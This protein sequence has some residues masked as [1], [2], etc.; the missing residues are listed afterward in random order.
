[1]IV[2]RRFSK[3]LSQAKIS[4][5]AALATVVTLGLILRLVVTLEFPNINH[6]DEIYQ[7]IEQA[8]RLTTGAGIV[9]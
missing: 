7:T 8:R 6:P 5:I 2:A 1:M 9:P 4:T 3:T